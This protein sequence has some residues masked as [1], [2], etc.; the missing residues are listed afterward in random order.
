VQILA[1][2]KPPAGQIVL[3]PR[4]QAY[5][6]QTAA[7][8]LENSIPPA[9]Q[10]I[11]PLADEL[12]AA[13]REIVSGVAEGCDLV[14]GSHHQLAVD[15]AREVSSRLRRAAENQGAK[16]HGIYPAND[17]NMV[18]GH[19]GWD[20]EVMMRVN[21]EAQYAVVGVD[22]GD[23]DRLMVL[24]REEHRIAAEKRGK[25]GPHWDPATETRNQWIYERAMKGDP[26]KRIQ[27]ALSAEC[28]PRGWERIETVQGIRKAAFDYAER[29][30]LSPP[31]RRKA[32]RPR[33]KRPGR[34]NIN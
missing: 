9:A 25:L 3:V 2:R 15:V 8:A 6:L 7:I 24:V 13:R 32:G 23:L 11:E 14:A 29:H 18:V 31:P 20:A 19:V 12:A 4:E 27:L 26:W 34:G 33:G 21:V 28:Q 16:F 22:P 17:G 1:S 30:G 5:V 10:A